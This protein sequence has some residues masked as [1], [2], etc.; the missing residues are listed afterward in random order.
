[1][2]DFIMS[3]DYKRFLKKQG[4]E[5]SDWEKATLFYNNR[6]LL[7]DDVIWGLLDIA[8]HTSDEVLKKQIE[9]RLSRNKELYEGFQKREKD[10]YYVLSV[11]S[12]TK[13]V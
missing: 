8:K 7:Y 13:K 2:S 11:W 5:L 12:D 4:I 9:D 6:Q 1:M 3:E 10:T